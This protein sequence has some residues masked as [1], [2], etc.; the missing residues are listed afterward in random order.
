MPS[1]TGNASAYYG[2]PTR[3]EEA[4]D[5]GYRCSECDTEYPEDAD[6][7][8]DCGEPFP[9]CPGCGDRADYG[10]HRRCNEIP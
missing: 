9:T 6:E 1:H 7:C 5:E 8:P 10:N 2:L 4:A 3:R